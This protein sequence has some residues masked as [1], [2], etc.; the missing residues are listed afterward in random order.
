MLNLRE[1]I[2]QRV[3]RCCS[4]RSLS[5][6]LSELVAL[7]TS[8]RAHIDLIALSPRPPLKLFRAFAGKRMRDKSDSM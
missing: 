4:C 7:A 1:I 3:R 8:C 5:N 2:N 6:Y